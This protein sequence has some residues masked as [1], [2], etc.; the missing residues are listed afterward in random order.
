MWER[1]VPESSGVSSLEGVPFRLCILAFIPQI[2]N[3]I[4]NTISGPD[5]I[6]Q[7]EGGA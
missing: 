7:F 2:G 5:G 6:G 1:S 3:G 4:R